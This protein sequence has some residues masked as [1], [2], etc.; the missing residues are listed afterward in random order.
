[1]PK[2]K[3]ILR[4]TKQKENGKVNQLDAGNKKDQHNSGE[5][6]TTH[7]VSK[8]QCQ[9]TTGYCR[10][11]NRKKKSKANQLDVGNK[12]QSTILVRTLQKPDASKQCQKTIGYCRDLHRKKNTKQTNLDVGNKKD[13][14]NSDGEKLQK[15]DAS[16]LPYDAKRQQNIEG[17]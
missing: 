13:Q 1:M 7:G 2:D 16:K 6:V 9:K 11:P 14:H 10:E 3:R 12:K 15:Q 5:K 4:G 8:L 17:N